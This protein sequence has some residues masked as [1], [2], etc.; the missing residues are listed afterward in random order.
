[1]NRSAAHSGLAWATALLSFALTGCHPAMSTQSQPGNSSQV[2]PNE[3]P[4][5]FRNHR[6]AGR[7]YNTLRCHI[8]YDSHDQTP[9][10]ADTEASP[11]PP[12]PDYRNGWG[13]ASYIVTR[14]DFP[15]PAE[16]RWTSLDGAEHEAKIDIGEIFKERKILH[17][18]PEAEIPEGWAHDITPN[19]FLEINDHTVNVY[20]MAHIATK[21][22]QMP[23]NKNSHHRT[24]VVL[25]WTRTY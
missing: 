20:M 11:A 16:A 19:I 8:V 22:E 1:M 4:L 2:V 3:F 12:S 5:K 21:A 17:Q 25:A 15:S 9:Y 18:V 10:G 13:S 14:R 24:D 23:G 7:C 6:F